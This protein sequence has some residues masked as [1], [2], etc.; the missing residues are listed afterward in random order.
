MTTHLQCYKGKMG[1]Y[2][3]KWIQPPRKIQG[4]TV[5][6]DY[7]KGNKFHLLCK[8]SNEFVFEKVWFLFEHTSAIS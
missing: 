7:L 8:Q 2:P 3:L 4:I 1:Y 6:K 5:K